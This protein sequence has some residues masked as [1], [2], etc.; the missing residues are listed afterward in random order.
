MGNTSSTTSWPL[1]TTSWFSGPVLSLELQ[2]DNCYDDH[3]HQGIIRLTNKVEELDPTEYN[4][5]VI[6]KMDFIRGA[7]YDEANDNIYL[8][9]E[10]LVY[11][12]DSDLNAVGDPTPIYIEDFKKAQCV[13][14]IP[15]YTPDF[16]I[17]LYAISI[18]NVDNEWFASP[19]DMEADPKPDNVKSLGLPKV[20]N[21]GGA[22]YMD[23]KLLVLN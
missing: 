5:S 1:Y 19:I 12:L 23:G 9:D 7:F 13:Q 22:Q 20:K 14:L 3:L 6:G 2:C 11:V 18:C 4:P 15:G 21:F 17:L 16:E 10:R 8:L